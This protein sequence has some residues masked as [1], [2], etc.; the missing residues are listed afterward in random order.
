MNLTYSSRKDSIY[1]KRFN[2]YIPDLSFISSHTTDMDSEQKKHL[3]YQ[4]VI[5]NDR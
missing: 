4:H 1:N 3:L 5:N 2:S